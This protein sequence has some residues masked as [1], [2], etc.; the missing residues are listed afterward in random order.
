MRVKVKRATLILCMGMRGTPQTRATLV[1]TASA[2]SSKSSNTASESIGCSASSGERRVTKGAMISLSVSVVPDS[3]LHATNPMF[4]YSKLPNFT[5][6]YVSIVA[7]TN[8]RSARTLGA[9][10]EV[11]NTKCPSEKLCSGASSS[12]TSEFSSGL[13]MSGCTVQRA[14]GRSR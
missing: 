7:F 6:V 2:T 9:S 8:P 12:T 1:N 14:Y 5:S 3:R 10:L 4:L 13:V 11:Q